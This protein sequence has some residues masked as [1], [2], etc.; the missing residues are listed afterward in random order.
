MKKFIL[1]FFIS[2]FLFGCNGAPTEYTNPDQTITIDKGNK[3]II[4]LDENRTTGY[5]WKF[6]NSSGEHLI[7]L[8]RKKHI[9][10]KSKKLGA[11][12]QVK[13]LFKAIGKGNTILPLVY[14][15]PWE[16]TKSP[17]KKKTFKIEIK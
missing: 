7:K 9:P 8:I 4:K 5:Q 1:I 3:F 2:L 14:V 12:G 6:S 10:S 16:K 13:L 11:G 15:R 17:K